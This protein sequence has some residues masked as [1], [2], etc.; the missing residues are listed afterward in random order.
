MAAGRVAAGR[1]AAGRQPGREGFKSYTFLND[2]GRGAKCNIWDS[3]RKSNYLADC[4]VGEV[5]L[6]RPK[7]K[8][9]ITILLLGGG[10]QVGSGGT[11]E[12]LFLLGGDVRWD[13]VGRQVGPGGTPEPLF[14]LGGGVPP[15]LGFIKLK[16]GRGGA[17]DGRG[18]AGAG[19]AWGRR[20]GPCSIVVKPRF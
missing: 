3:D 16:R 18:G 10:R 1:V 11:S 19:W 2:S 9:S 8:T 20:T 5:M 14:L 12:P 15:R 17:Q 13:Q 6:F 4:A 7:C